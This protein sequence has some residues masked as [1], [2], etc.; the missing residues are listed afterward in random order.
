MLKTYK[1]ILVG[2]GGVGKSNFCN[3]AMNFCNRAMNVAFDKRYIA[4]L[5]V[6][7][8]PIRYDDVVFNAWDTAGQEKFG[9]LRTGYYTHGNAAI[10][11]CDITAKMT[12][13]AVETWIE[14]VRKV[15]PDIP[16][17]VV[18]NK[19]DLKGADFDE[20][21]WAVQKAVWA[22]KGCPTLETSCKTNEG[23]NQVM[24]HL[25]EHVE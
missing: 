3:R 25:I 17:V 7:V 18:A 16:I 21:A 14:R 10:V 2:D 4:T 9:G 11:M 13:E 12:I 6:E 20:N 1:L 22:L 5:G 15:C 24:D 23:I 8:H 19:I